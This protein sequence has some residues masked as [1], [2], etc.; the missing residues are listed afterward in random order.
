M[1]D[2]LLESLL[3]EDEGTVL[4]FKARE[5]PF[6][7]ATDDQK[8]KLLKNILAMA[9]AWRRIDAYI[10]VG[11]DEIRGGRSITKSSIPWSASVSS[12]T[13]SRS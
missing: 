3:N 10:L 12:M 7:A 2:A 9:N 6:E 1:N 13:R 4:D 5:Y 8:G 11:V